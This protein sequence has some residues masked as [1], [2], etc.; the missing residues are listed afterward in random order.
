MSPLLGDEGA[1]PGARFR[2]A[3]LDVEA[4]ERIGAVWVCVALQVFAPFSSGTAPPEVPVLASAAEPRPRLAR[5]VVG[6]ATSERL[7]DGCRKA[8]PSPAAAKLLKVDH[9]IDSRGPLLAFGQTSKRSALFSVVA[10]VRFGGVRLAAW[11][12]WARTRA[13]AA[14]RAEMRFLGMDPA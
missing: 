5:A 2:P 6:L 10:A 7:L 4:A 8:E 12:E 3:A 1:V 9:C 14:I 11:A 13:R